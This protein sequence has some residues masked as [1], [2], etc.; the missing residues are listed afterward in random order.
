M[1]TFFFDSDADFNNITITRAGANKIFLA[2]A[3]APAPPKLAG[4]MAPRCG[5][6]SGSPLARK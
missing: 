4:S 1:Q 6:D 2:P 5:S 3:P